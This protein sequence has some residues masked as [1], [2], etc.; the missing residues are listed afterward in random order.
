MEDLRDHTNLVLYEDYRT[1]K[2]KMMGLTD[3]SEQKYVSVLRSKVS[4]M[5][6]DAV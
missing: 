2:L 1:N 6:G 5:D 4:R 3:L